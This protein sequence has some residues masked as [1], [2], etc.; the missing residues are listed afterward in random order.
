MQHVTQKIDHSTSKHQLSENCFAIC[1]AVA[2]NNGGWVIQDWEQLVEVLWWRS[3][4]LLG[5]RNKTEMYKY[6]M[7]K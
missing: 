2:M 4:L 6:L 1:F 7:G 3:E 5:K